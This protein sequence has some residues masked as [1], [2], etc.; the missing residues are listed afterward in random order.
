MPDMTLT[1]ALS[2]APL[3]VLIV[4]VGRLPADAR[5]RDV[6][7]RRGA[8]PARRAS[9]AARSTDVVHHAS[10]VAAPTS[11]SPKES[12]ARVACFGRGR[13]IESDNR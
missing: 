6:H 8:R 10:P 1:E 13:M 4:V 9:S 2:M 5:R 12:P 11:R 7:E 3:C